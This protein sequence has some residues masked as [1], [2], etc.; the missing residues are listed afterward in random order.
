LAR[1]FSSEF[2]RRV[3]KTLSLVS[4][5]KTC[6]ILLVFSRVQVNPAVSQC[7]RITMKKQDG[8][9]YERNIDGE[10]LGVPRPPGL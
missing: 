8:H 9:Y 7:R 4:K 6:A 3:K 5:R 2:P 1:P 10:Y